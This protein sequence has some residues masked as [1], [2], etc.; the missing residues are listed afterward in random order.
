MKNQIPRTG[1]AWTES[2]RRLDLAKRMCLDR[3]AEAGLGSQGRS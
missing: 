3:V 1:F 2:Y